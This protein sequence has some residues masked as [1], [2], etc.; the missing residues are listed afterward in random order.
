MLNRIYNVS[1]TR[2]L[3]LL[4]LLFLSLALAA[5]GLSAEDMKKE[6][7]SYCSVPANCKGD[8]GETGEKGD[9]GD[10]GDKGDKGDQGDKGEAGA[11]GDKGDQGDPGAKGDQGDKGEKG[12]KGDKG[13]QGD[14]GLSPVV[15][16]YEKGIE[17]SL[18]STGV[19]VSL[20]FSTKV[21]DAS[22]T[23]NNTGDRFTFAAPSDGTYLINISVGVVYTN[24]TTTANA[25]LY[26]DKNGKGSNI[27]SGE[28]RIGGALSNGYATLKI[29][30]LVAL[31]KGDKINFNV[32]RNGGGSGTAKIMS[33]IRFSF[34]NIHKVSDK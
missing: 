9:K 24:F 10:P 15:V 13:D 17:K 20:G 7:E 33:D 19:P 14:S 29:S 21:F 16:R 31:K 6:I 18:P 27:I 1:V 4:S 28:E 11:K 8:K 5:C 12:D 3:P 25:T 34:V 30:D 22:N 23:S 26:L 32:G 2:I